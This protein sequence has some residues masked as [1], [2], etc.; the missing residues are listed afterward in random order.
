MNDL[1][2]NDLLKYVDN[3]MFTN[4]EDSGKLHKQFRTSGKVSQ[5]KVS[6]AVEDLPELASGANIIRRL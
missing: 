6:L 1:G 4:Q 5:D 2:F 3:P